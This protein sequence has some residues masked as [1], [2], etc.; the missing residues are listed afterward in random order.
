MAV[1][2]VKLEFLGAELDAS[3]NGQR[4]DLAQRERARTLDVQLGV[5]VAQLALGRPGLL[6]QA[7]DARL[8]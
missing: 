5:L 2:R 4:L 3:G 1:G 7:Q 6:A 8:A